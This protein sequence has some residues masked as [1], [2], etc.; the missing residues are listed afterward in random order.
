MYTDQSRKAGSPPAS[1]AQ[2]RCRVIFASTVRILRTCT[3]FYSCTL[4]AVNNTDYGFGGQ[5]DPDPSPAATPGTPKGLAAGPGARQAPLMGPNEGPPGWRRPG[6]PDARPGP[7]ALPPSAPDP[8]FDL[9]DR[10][11]PSAR[12]PQFSMKVYRPYCTHPFTSTRYSFQ[13]RHLSC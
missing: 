6:G 11:A 2:N 4:A 8:V 3:V 9:V 13:P 1:A 12:P 5:T 7:A 10:R